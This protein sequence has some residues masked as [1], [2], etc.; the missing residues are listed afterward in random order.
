V[1]RHSL[2]TFAF[3]ALGFSRDPGCGGVDD[4]DGRTN[5]PCTRSSDCGG[6]LVCLEGVC[7]E[8]DEKRPPE[9]AGG[10]G[11]GATADAGGGAVTV[12]AGGGGVTDGG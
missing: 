6:D 2:T 1:V 9:D 8:P 5:A 4:P 12:D 3:V 11:G 7:R 10:G